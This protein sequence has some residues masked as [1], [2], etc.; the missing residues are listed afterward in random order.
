MKHVYKVAPKPQK[1]DSL[2]ERIN[3]AINIFETNSFRYGRYDHEDMKLIHVVIYILHNAAAY[4][5][6]VSN[7]PTRMALI[8]EL[9]EISNSYHFHQQTQEISDTLETLIPEVSEIIEQGTEHPVEIARI[10]R[11]LAESYNLRD[12]ETQEEASSA[13]EVPE[14]PKAPT[15]IIAQ[16]MH[17]F[18]AIFNSRG[19]VAAST[20]S[21][22]TAEESSPYLMESNSTVIPS[23]VCRG[24][25]SYDS[26]N[27]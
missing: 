27:I 11:F 8:E 17:C 13:K 21:N 2:R 1:S 15:G 25:D 26:H 12:Q 16:M 18:F 7:N 10:A 20:D 6:L 4:L 9:I 3:E 22:Q 23:A 14:K 19:E 5:P 24:D